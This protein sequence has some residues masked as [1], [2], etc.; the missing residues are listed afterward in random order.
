MDFVPCC[1]PCGDGMW[2]RCNTDD[3]IYTTISDCELR[4]DNDTY[5]ESTK[6]RTTFND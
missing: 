2:K 6:S 4:G 3:C 5:F 1:E